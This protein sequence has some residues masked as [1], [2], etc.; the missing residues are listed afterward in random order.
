MTA[1]EINLLAFLKSP[2]QFLIP[3]YQRTYSWTRDQCEQLWKDIVRAATDDAVSGHF[4]GSIVYVEKGLYQVASVPQLLVIDGQQRLTSVSL[5]LAAFGNALGRGGSDGEMTTKKIFNYFLFNS[6]EEGELRYKLLLTQGDRT[7]L[8]H[9]L[10]G[11]TSPASGSRRIAEN[12]APGIR[13][14]R[15]RTTSYTGQSW[16]CRTNRYRRTQPAARRQRIAR[17]QSG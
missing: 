13:T 2:K 12:Y 15:L 7:T 14:C 4:V 16:W 3:I 11:L 8:T 1:K 9:I 5:L 17:S 6:E 10:D